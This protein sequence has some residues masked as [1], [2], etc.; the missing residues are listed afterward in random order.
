M[1][2]V[3][4]KLPEAVGIRFSY[5]WR[6]Y[7]FSTLPLSIGTYVCLGGVGRL[8]LLCF[9]LPGAEG[10]PAGANSRF[11]GTGHHGRRGTQAHLETGIRPVGAGLGF[12]ARSALSAR[13]HGTPCSAAAPPDL[14]QATFQLVLVKQVS[15][16]CYSPVSRWNGKLCKTNVY[17]LTWT[18]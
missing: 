1:T 10:T 13:G 4:F 5:D 11:V 18:Q 16:S 3:M 14:R 9:S 8:S 15:S 2:H 7:T 6:K 17:R 12:R